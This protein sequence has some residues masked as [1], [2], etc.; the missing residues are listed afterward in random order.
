[1]KYQY[2]LFHYQGQTLKLL[3]VQGFDMLFY[4]FQMSILITFFIIPNLDYLLVTIQN[5]K[6]I[7]NGLK[8]V[9]NHPA[10][11]YLFQENLLN[12]ILKKL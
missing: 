7:Y 2:K 10:Y 6:L 11:F 9:V 8:V 4:K 1:M 3:Y 5:A 12:S